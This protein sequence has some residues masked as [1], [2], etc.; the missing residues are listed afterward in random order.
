MLEVDQGLPVRVDAGHRGPNRAAREFQDGPRPAGAPDERAPASP[1]QRGEEH[2][3]HPA[4]RPP[5]AA[6]EPRLAHGGVVE[7]QQVA[8]AEEPGQV[9]EPRVLHRARG[10]V[11]RQESGCVAHAGRFLRYPLGR[12]VEVEV[13]QSLAHCSSRGAG[14]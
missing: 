7:Y 3:L 10:A 13:F 12:Q 5:L 1:A 9:R 4:V 8:G 11:E 2:R 14:L 6:E